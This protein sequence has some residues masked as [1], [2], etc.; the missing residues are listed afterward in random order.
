MEAV[1]KI[2]FVLTIWIISINA[3]FSQK[4]DDLGKLAKKPLFRDTIYDGAADPCVIYNRNTQSWFMFYTNR[5]A[6]L[7]DTTNNVSWVHGTP[8]GIAESKDQGV[9]WHYKQTVV[10]NYGNDSTTFWAPEVYYYK[11]LYHMYITIVPGIFT[12][13]KHPRHIVHFT[14]ENLIDWIFVAQLK[15]ASDKV[16]DACIIQLPDSSWRLWY[17]NEQDRKSIY[18][19]DSPDLYQWTDKGKILFDGSKPGEGPNVFYWENTFFMIVD[20]WRGLGVYSSDDAI[21]WNRQP[22]RILDVPGLGNQDN[23]IGQHAD[24]VVSNNRA[25][26][27]YFTHPGRNNPQNNAYEKARSLIQVAELSL[28][29]KQLTCNRDIPVNIQLLKP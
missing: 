17:N 27:F 21:H 15:L 11:G 18:Y 5:R 2:S 13:W 12:N 22:E 9:S 8:I 7:A 1:K 25:Y 4:A 20:E 14:S 29:N 23:V 6:T 24:V 10:F 3:A 16:I 19:A 26:I 28:D